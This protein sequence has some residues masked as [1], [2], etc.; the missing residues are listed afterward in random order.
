MAVFRSDQA[1]ITFAAEAAQGGDAERLSIASGTATAGYLNGVVVPGAT[2][3]V[4]A[5]S[6]AYVV[7]DFVRIG[8]SG[9]I[10]VNSEVRRIEH[11]SGTGTALTLFLD[12]PLAFY[13]PTGN[14][15]GGGVDR[16]TGAST[17]V[18]QGRK[19]ITFVPGVYETVEVPDPEMTIEPRYFLGTQS[20]RNYFQAYRGQQS[21][22][23]SIGD[24]LLLNGWPLRFPIGK[25]ITIPYQSNGSTIA[26]DSTIVTTARVDKGDVFILTASNA[27]AVN[28][29]V[30]VDSVAAG[31]LT[32][33]SKCEVRRVVTRTST[34]IEVDYPLTLK[35]DSGC[36]VSKVTAA[37]SFYRHHILETIDLDTVSWH[38]HMRDSGE[39]ALNDFDRRYVG[40]MVGSM[41]ISAEEGGLL[42]CGWDTVPFMEMVHNQKG[43]T[44]T[45]PV[46]DAGYGGGS[47]SDSA[48]TDMPRFA[49]MQSITGSDINK[50]PGG[51]SAAAY[52]VLAD[53]QDATVLGEP[54][55]FSRGSVKFSN[56]E[57][58]RVRSFSLTVGNNEEPRYYIKQRFGRHRGPSEIREQQREYTMT[59]DIAL[60]DSAASASA[61]GMD[62][63]TALFK[64]LLLEGDYGSDASPNMIGFTVSLEFIRGTNDRIVIDMPGIDAGAALG[65]PGTPTT[66]AK[67][68]NNQGVFIRT[69]PHGI[70][71]ENPLQVSVDMLIRNIKITVD[72]NIPVY[73]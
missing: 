30:V 66:P 29:Y 9:I 19:Y 73:P 2:Q 61:Q 20:K 60:P 26:M 46:L 70:S 49:L 14:T 59:A 27:F 37:K 38:I 17:A 64:E 48:T 65:T 56:V 45:N 39:E 8:D 10:N 71:G 58:A 44:R 11:I 12:R 22:S 7:G 42:T 54:Y 62:S 21:L 1:Q 33:N 69:A 15:T 28:D 35:H 51:G 4:T 5:G 3:I 50:L 57:F 40:G 25:V 55:Y 36:S 18:D 52:D 41:T 31:S 68:G 16:V 43:H 67:G 23:G 34:S 72:D 6:S 24:M 13:H 47:L 53:Q 32:G 63:A